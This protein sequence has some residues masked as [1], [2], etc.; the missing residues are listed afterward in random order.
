MFWTIVLKSGIP[1]ALEGWW[2]AGDIVDPKWLQ[3]R[4]LGCLCASFDIELRALNYSTPWGYDSNDAWHP[5]RAGSCAS[6]SL[7]ER[8]CQAG[9]PSMVAN[10]L[11]NSFS[12]PLRNV[13]LPTS[14]R[15]GERHDAEYTSRLRLMC[16][17]DTYSS[18][19]TSLGQTVIT[20]PACK[21]LTHLDVEPLAAS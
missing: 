12:F 4:R 5:V 7:L 17:D 20:P 10:L 18:E 6:G 8:H 1:W 9:R 3:R 13:Y 15:R 11:Q 19:F 21:W 2:G 14:L 16:M